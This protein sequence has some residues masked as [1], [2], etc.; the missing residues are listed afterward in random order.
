MKS[1]R[2]LSV[3]IVIALVISLLPAVLVGAAA[4]DKYKITVTETEGSKISTAVTEAA[5]FDNVALSLDMLAGSRLE[6]I[7]VTD[8]NGIRLNIW[9]DEDGSYSF[10]MPASAVNVAA[11]FGPFG[12]PQVIE[13]TDVANTD[14]CYEAVYYC[15]THGYMN[16]T[17]DGTTFSPEMN[18]TRA[19]AATV[20]YRVSGDTAVADVGTKFSDVEVGSWYEEAVNWAAANKITTGVGDNKF[21]PEGALNYEQWIT[22]LNRYSLY[23]KYDQSVGENT[24]ILS[25][26]DVAEVSQW[27]IGAYQWVCGEAIIEHEDGMLTPYKDANR[28]LLA[29]TIM[30]MQK[31]YGI[32]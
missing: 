5:E 15:Y 11:R 27:A 24:N 6:E 9:V 20:L 4:E 3:V 23:K 16:G 25:Y 31:A 10:T 22:M 30:N 12:S 29:K 8:A 18:L 17:G 1:S 14:D 7:I 21:N 26:R 13:F 2:L 19:M 28:T 32:Y